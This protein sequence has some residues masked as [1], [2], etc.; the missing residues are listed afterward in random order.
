[1]V[2]YICLTLCQTSSG[3]KDLQEHVFTNIYEEA[4]KNEKQISLHVFRMILSG[5]PRSGKTTFWKRLTK[6]KGFQPSEN[7]PSTPAFESHMISANENEGSN[8]NIKEITEQ[9]VTTSPHLEA[10][11]LFD[12]HLYDDTSDLKNEALTIYR[13]ILNEPKSVTSDSTEQSEAISESYSDESET[14]VLMRNQ[15]SLDSTQTKTISKHDELEIVDSN[16]SISERASSP[17]PEKVSTVTEKSVTTTTSVKGSDPISKEI[18]EYLEELNALL[19]S[20]EKMTDIQ[21]IKA[22][23]KLCNLIDVGGQRAFLEMLP[24]VTIGKALYLL[25]FSYEN[26]EK[27]INE[28]VQKRDNPEEV[29]TGT[30]YKQMDVIMQSLICVSTTSKT[31]SDNVALLVGTHVDK[32]KPQD[33]DRVNGIICD[34]VKSFLGSSL[35]YAEKGQR[36]KDKLVLEVSI[37]PNERCSNKPED[38]Q[39]VIMNLVENRL[40]CSES[41]K[42][43][44]SWYMFSILLRRIQ[45]AGH[46][47]VQYHHCQQIAHK[48][49]IKPKHLQSLLDRMHR[50]L[51][52]VLYFPEVEQLKDIV[53]CDPAAVYK[54][55]SELIFNSFDVRTHPLL[56]RRLK[57]WGVF[58]VKELKERCKEQK[59]CQLQLDKLLILLQHLGIIAPVDVIKSDSVPSVEPAQQSD[60]DAKNLIHPEYLIPC[61]LDD[62]QPA[63]LKVQIQE[64]QAMSIIPL[65]IYFSCGFAPMGG[66]CYLFTKLITNNHNKGWQLLLPD[67]FDETS[68]SKNDNYWRNKV[69]F[70]VDKKYIVILS[71][72]S[73]YYEIHIIHSKSE[74]PF[75]LGREG[76]YICKKVWDAVIQ[77]LSSS[78]NKSQQKYETACKCINHQMLEGYDGH[79][80]TFDHNPDDNR[81]EIGAV[82]SQDK[83]SVIVNDTKQSI[84]VWFK[85][86]IINSFDQRWVKL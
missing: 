3:I 82:C 63:D 14:P 24:T 41:E 21:L 15:P 67:I 84:T 83:T 81:P 18:D 33:V 86:C 51:G 25:F 28:T 7:S 69:T 6:L 34:N 77:I 52:I 19:K 53:I 30:I 17:I 59:G 43:P 50:I 47:V 85:V 2:L 65:R 16:A 56:A 71:S 73:E 20:N 13:H 75:Q 26:F 45:F 42:L 10:A 78:L 68:Q 57:K 61:I 12:L 66:F 80:M 32:V 72:T 4:L 40:K 11:M 44:A 55:I 37:A 29:C 60:I 22:I 27:E 64:A 9:E 38:Y 58:M 5:V 39:E 48:L 46:S 74:K 8:V 31:S 62:A 76:C 79:V 49:H 70:K 1:M 23:K 36:G 54:S 35:V